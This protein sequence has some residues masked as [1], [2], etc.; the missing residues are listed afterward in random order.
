MT[1]VLTH[2]KLFRGGYLTI[3]H[4]GIRYTYTITEMVNFLVWADA[5]GQG[6]NLFWADEN[7]VGGV[8]AV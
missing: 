6:G 7:D 5:N 1:Q 3:E 4:L 2:I 8:F